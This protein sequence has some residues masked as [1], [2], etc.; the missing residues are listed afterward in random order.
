MGVIHHMKFKI[1]QRVKMT[2]WKHS[3]EFKDIEF[4][5][6]K[7]DVLGY[8]ITTVIPDQLSENAFTVQ[9]YHIYIHS[10]ICVL[11]VNKRLK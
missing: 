1:G 9:E 10:L 4:I 7:I 3:S 5:I 11:S 2:R 6:N 8:H